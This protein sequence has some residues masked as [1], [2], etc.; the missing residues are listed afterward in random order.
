MSKSAWGNV[1]AWAEEAERA[2]AE[3]REAAAK[4]SAAAPSAG[5]PSLKESVTSG[6][7]KKKTKM[8]LQ[9]FTLQHSSYPGSG[10]SQGLTAEEMFHLPTGPKQRSDEEL[11]SGRLGG[12]FSNYGPRTGSSTYNNTKMGRRSYGYDEDER[13][14]I[15]SL[16]RASDFNQPSRA[17]EVDNWGSMKKPT[18][19]EHFRNQ[20]RPADRYS[21]LGSGSAT[22]IA[23]RADEVDNWASLKKPAAQDRPSNIGP[24]TSS[25]EPDLQNL[26]LDA[27]NHSEGEK[28]LNKPNPFGAARPREEVLAEKGLDWKKMDL[29]VGEKKPQ[30]VNS[31]S[32]PTSSQS[33]SRPGSSNSSRIEEGSVPSAGVSEAIVMQKPRVNPFGDA[34]PREV[35]LAAKGLDWRQVDLELESRRTGSRTDEEKKLKEEIDFLR[36]ELLEK[37]AEEK[38]SIHDQILQKERDLKELS[39]KVLVGYYSD[40]PPSRPGSYGGRQ[41]GFSDRPHSRSGSSHEGLLLPHQD[42]EHSERPRSR[43]G[44]SNSW[45]RP[46]DDRRSSFQGGGKRGF[47]ANRDV[48]R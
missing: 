7:Q 14:G 19:V 30:P 25:N 44:A 10:T 39:D 37:S 41:S 40:R 32:R 26:V 15:A 27:A 4:S 5:F 3:E 43:G 28:K 33:N 21:P 18:S 48:D 23:S 46:N 20:A 11:R 24:A 47:A 17:D 13:R 35:L 9:E 6:K 34:K 8:S 45:G 29:D 12:G 22:G 38:V 16:P 31:S 2:E 42:A 1:G 36:T